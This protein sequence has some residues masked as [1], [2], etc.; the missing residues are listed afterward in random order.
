M[1]A[2]RF[3]VSGREA[4]STSNQPSLSDPQTIV[5][6]RGW[7][8][9]AVSPAVYSTEFLDYPRWGQKTLG[10]HRCSWSCSDRRWS[11]RYSPTTSC[12][13]SPGADEDVARFQLRDRSLSYLEANG[14][15]IGGRASISSEKVQTLAFGL[16]H[17]LYG[18]TKFVNT[19]KG[20][21]L[22]NRR[23]PVV[24]TRSVLSNRY[25][26]TRFRMSTKPRFKRPAQVYRPNEATRR[27]ARP[28]GH[29]WPPHRA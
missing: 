20:L 10:V 28:A 16:G 17:I 22:R 19:V 15:V 24:L 18:L 5:T 11:Q 6:A 1:N 21:E 3:S 8:K 2:R 7:L 29:I 23:T 27:T 13:I 12:V 9:P 26:E 4:A 25:G 14:L